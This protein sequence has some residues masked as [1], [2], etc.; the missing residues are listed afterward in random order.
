MAVV[1]LTKIKHG[2]ADGTVVELE[3]G[4]KI[5]GKTF[6]KEEL[7]A[8]QASGS[9]GQPAAES[10][11]ELEMAKARVAELEAQLAEREEAAKAN[12]KPSEPG[13]T[14]GAGEEEGK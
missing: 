3:P 2:N 11:Q 5:P 4:D 1:A 13:I 8:L 12:E 10:N 9:I 14:P 6:S 7:E